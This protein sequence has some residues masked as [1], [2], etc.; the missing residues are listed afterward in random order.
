MNQT[1][2][3][4]LIAVV[5]GT[6][7][8]I[9]DGKLRL[10]VLDEATGEPIA[11]RMTL[12]RSSGTPAPIRRAIKAGVGSAIDGQIDIQLPA[13]TYRF[14]LSHGPEYHEVQ[15]TFVLEDNSEDVKT[16][17]I[18]QIVS[19]EDEGWIA[20]DPIAQAPNQL[21]PRTKPIGAK[22]IGATH[23]SSPNGATHNE[24]QTV[25]RTIWQM[26]GGTD[27]EIR[28]R[29][30]DLLV[31]GLVT[32]EAI[33]FGAENAEFS[34]ARMPDSPEIRLDLMRGRGN[35]SDLVVVG[36]PADSP[37][38]LVENA[39]TQLRTAGESG[40][41][42]DFLRLATS[43]KSSAVQARDGGNESQL[44]ATP[45]P[46]I[47]IMNPMAWDLPIWLA[48]ERIDGIVVLGEFLKPTGPTLSWPNSRKPDR[49]EMVGPHA[50]GGWS[51][52][53]YQQLL[54]AGIYLPPLGTSGAGFQPNP[55]GYTRTYVYQPETE[56]GS[57]PEVDSQTGKS[58]Q[59]GRDWWNNA[60]AG[61]TVITSGPLLRPMLEAQP[62]GHTFFG[63]SAQPLELLLTLQLAIRDP[64]DYLEV[65]QDGR[66][67]Y[68]ARLD[69]FA[70]QGGRIPP[71]IFETSGWAMVRV[72]TK[73]EEH[74]R[75]AISAPWFVTIDGKPRI[76]AKAVEF[77]QQ[78]LSQRERQ[79]AELPRQEVVKQA[80]YVRAAREFWARRAE[81]ANAP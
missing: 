74:Y 43:L 2:L 14:T 24:A 38:P 21:V 32:P 28:A 25:P 41:S 4:I 5:F 8:A 59:T 51:V 63:S 61:R 46:R 10:H 69:E 16:I 48:S 60:W 31:V 40:P 73:Y 72:M 34:Q 54:E 45:A 66:V 57:V 26:V 53:I 55:L 11:A 49:L 9:A 62:P 42:S 79:L 71:L 29:A 19:L 67:T 20:G 22:P 36:V 3:L 44:D 64:V 76:S 50:L 15:G 65:I 1:G 12:F 37:T 78:W 35:A 58:S 17:R 81:L 6:S 33:A 52:F 75:A 30:E 23:H 70:S 39:T 68:K 7:P 56:T 13:D 18:P 77:F 47:V 80:P 27:W